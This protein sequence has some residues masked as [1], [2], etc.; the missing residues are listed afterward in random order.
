M[1]LGH[2]D[3]SALFVYAADH[4]SRL[5]IILPS[6][7]L[8]LGPAKYGFLVGGGLMCSSVAS[9]V[10]TTAV[11]RRPRRRMMVIAAISTLSPI[12]LAVGAASAGPHLAFLVSFWCLA[13]VATAGLRVVY[14]QLVQAYSRDDDGLEFPFTCRS[15]CC[16][17][18]ELVSVLCLAFAIAIG[19][20]AP[21][22]SVV[23]ALALAGIAIGA[24]RHLPI[25]NQSIIQVDTL[26]DGYF[27]FD[28]TA[29]FVSPATI[30][31]DVAIVWR[32]PA[33]LSLVV[34]SVV[35]TTILEAVR[36]WLPMFL[37]NVGAVSPPVGA[38]AFTVIPVGSIGASALLDR[39]TPT[40]ETHPNAFLLLSAIQLVAGVMLFGLS[41]TKSSVP[42]SLVAILVGPIV[43]AASASY[44][45]LTDLVQHR[46]STLDPR[47]ARQIQAIVLGAGALVA[48]MTCVMMGQLAQHASWSAALA[49]LLLVITAGS[50][51]IFS[52]ERGMLRPQPC[53]RANDAQ[54][55]LLCDR[56]LPR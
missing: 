6:G 41:S 34:M 24:S 19:S 17:I 42:L 12:A 15:L 11:A 21:I 38:L 28:N 18:A 29:A 22:V 9:A 44:A 2:G 33:F 7:Q 30:P 16:S 25:P 37:A 10:G 39:F 55:E 45:I 27:E 46:A 54:S 26:D 48:S 52:Q 50:V 23:V 13:A 8:G 14:T 3:V 5:Q 53:Q 35:S 36:Y 20:T 4:L 43:A 32:T 51:A 56:E 40:S 31:R 49:L 1:P 47:L